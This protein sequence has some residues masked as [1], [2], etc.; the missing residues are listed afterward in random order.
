[1]ARPHWHLHGLPFRPGVFGFVSGS[2]EFLLGPATHFRDPCE[3]KCFYFR[4]ELFQHCTRRYPQTSGQLKAPLSYWH[5]GFSSFSSHNF[6]L[7]CCKTI[8]RDN[9]VLKPNLTTRRCLFGRLY[10]LLPTEQ[11]VLEWLMYVSVEARLYFRENGPAGLSSYLRELTVGVGLPA[12]T[13][14]PL[15]PVSPSCH[16]VR[17]C[18]AIST[19]FFHKQNLF[20]WENFKIKYLFSE[21]ESDISITVE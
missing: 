11:R 13:A 18:A 21:F 5:F 15:L 7:W 16:F 19:I 10:T 20:T 2:S 4:G 17:Y 8:S 14:R 6:N 3:R 9:L 12:Q 1:M